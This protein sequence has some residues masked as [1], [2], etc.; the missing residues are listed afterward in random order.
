MGAFSLI[1]TILILYNEKNID[2]K[3]Y[4]NI[5]NLDRVLNFIVDNF[6]I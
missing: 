4:I 2:Q 6:D 5:S 1:S 3:V